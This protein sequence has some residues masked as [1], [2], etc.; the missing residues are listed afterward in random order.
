M[1][2]LTAKE[3]AKMLGYS[4]IHTRYLARAGMIPSHRPYPGA[5][6]IIFYKEEIEQC[7]VSGKE[8]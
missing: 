2:V 6:R 8:C 5:R 1:T 7:Q 4:A 3:V